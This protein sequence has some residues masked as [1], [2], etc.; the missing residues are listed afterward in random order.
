MLITAGRVL[1]YESEADLRY[2]DAARL[3]HGDRSIGNDYIS[4]QANELVEIVCKN[5]DL[6]TNY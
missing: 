6:L 5:V 2:Q 1:N 3:R 4:N